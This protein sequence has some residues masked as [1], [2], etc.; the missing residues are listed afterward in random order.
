MKKILLTL[1]ISILPYQSIQ[2]FPNEPSGA[3][4]LTYESSIDD[5]IKLFPNAKR[6]E[7]QSDGYDQYIVD[8]NKKIYNLQPTSALFHFMDEKLYGVDIKFEPEKVYD[9]SGL[10][11]YYSPENLDAIVYLMNLAGK[12][13]D[14]DKDRNSLLKL[15]IL[16]EKRLTDLHGEPEFYEYGDDMVLTLWR[17][18]VSGIALLELG[19]VQIINTSKLLEFN[20]RFSEMAKKIKEGL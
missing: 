6:G 13:N 10:D 5:L 20:R 2:A 1:L 8:L 4:G 9:I 7:I 17:G 19:S 14:I 15:N 16:L 3:L 12:T 18:H 11:S